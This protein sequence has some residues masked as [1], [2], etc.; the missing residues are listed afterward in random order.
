MTASTQTLNHISLVSTSPEQ[1]GIKLNDAL[2]AI[3]ANG[4][5]LI[6]IQDID[7]F[8]RQTSSRNPGV[9]N[10]N[11]MY[12]SPGNSEYFAKGVSIAGD[13]NKPVIGGTMEE[14]AWLTASGELGGG[15]RAFPVAIRQINT[16]YTR[17]QVTHELLLIWKKNDGWTDTSDGTRKLMI[18]I[19]QE[20]IA[21]GAIGACGYVINSVVSSSAKQVRNVSNV[22]LPSG[23]AA[24]AYMDIETMELV[25]I[26]SCC[27]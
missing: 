26:P 20:S 4:R 3:T 15:Q 27:N 16:R 13:V 19:A 23:G 21:P 12:R 22:T 9:Y 11:I 5:D 7:V 1:L 6:E 14:M 18:A 2:Q 8:I 10:V 24:W 17:H 25:C